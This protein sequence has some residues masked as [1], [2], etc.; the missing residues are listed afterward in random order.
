MSDNVTEIPGWLPDHS[1]PLG[2]RSLPEILRRVANPVEPF[3]FMF[4]PDGLQLSPLEGIRD[5]L[6]KQPDLFAQLDDCQINELQ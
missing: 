1:R 5:S 6:G 3:G 2:F 4:V